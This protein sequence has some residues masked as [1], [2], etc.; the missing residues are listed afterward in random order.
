M[1][2]KGNSENLKLVDHNY[3]R[4]RCEI[5]PDGGALG[6]DLLFLRRRPAKK[7]L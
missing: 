3:L 7:I 2:D 1:A 5:P 4:N 6:R